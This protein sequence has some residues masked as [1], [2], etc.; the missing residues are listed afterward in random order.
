MQRVL[1]S[2]MMFSVRRHHASDAYY[3]LAFFALVIGIGSLLL[4]LP[5]SWSAGTDQR[6]SI[7]YIDALFTAT[8]AVC[9]TG[10][11]TVDTALFSRFGHIIILLLIQ[12][13]GLGII[14]FTSILLTIPGRRL[15]L[16]RLK[17]IRSFYVSGVEYEPKKIVRTIVIFTFGIEAVGAV[18]LA[19]FFKRAGAADPVFSG[20]FHSVSAFCNAGF[21]VYTTNLELF[22]KHSEILLSIAFLIVA[23]GLGFIVLQ[24]LERLLLR[25]RKRLSYHSQVVLGMTGLLILSCT[26]LFWYLEKDA[27]YAHLGSIDSMVNALFQAITPRTAGFDAIIQDKL[28]QPSKVMTLFLMFIGGAPGS[29]AGGI[30]VTTAFVIAVVMVKRPDKN[31]D[32]T[33]LKRRLS[34]KTTNDAIV[35]FLKAGALLFVSALALSLIEGTKGAAFGDIVFESIS[36]F[37]TVGLS[38]GLTTELSTAG[39]LIIIGTMFAGRVGLI[40]IAFPALRREADDIAYTEG[41]VLLG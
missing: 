27:A 13:G 30:K 21:S 32:I 18:L 23:G 20:L 10:L 9:V 17:T 7:P 41:T 35:Y 15:P 14:S 22:S 37:G 34:A 29:I 25:K 36:A 19:F 8:S 3:L 24:D 12:I 5:F 39:K 38:L 33:I 26:F 2:G 6:D 40:A 4:S 16:R 28:R 11:I 1:G 31:G